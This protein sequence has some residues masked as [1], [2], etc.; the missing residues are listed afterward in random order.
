[1]EEARKRDM[2]HFLQ[3]IQSVDSY[4]SGVYVI[5]KGQRIYRES[6]YGEFIAECAGGGDPHESVL[7]QQLFQEKYG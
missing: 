4:I 7:F 5:F 2:G 6:L 1:M 3:Y